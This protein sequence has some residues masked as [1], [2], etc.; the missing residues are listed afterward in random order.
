MT[1]QGRTQEIGLRVRLF[2]FLVNMMITNKKIISVLAPMLLLVL[3]ISGVIVGLSMPEVMAE[4]ISKP[5]VIKEYVMLPPEVI[6]HRIEVPVEVI[7][8]VSVIK[9]TVQWRNIYDR[10]FKN[11]EQFREWYYDQNF[12]PLC[13]SG[14][15]KVDCDDYAQRLQIAALRQGYPISIALLKEGKYYGVA[16]SDVEGGHAGNL[17]MINGV[18]YYVEP[19]P[20]KFDIVRI[21]QRD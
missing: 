7:K 3:W 12:N 20:G 14:A 16:V 1:E 8:E 2:L 13:P 21:I 17:V 5:Q 4:P 19:D 11:V 10:N 18:Y 15:Y 9:E 6:Y